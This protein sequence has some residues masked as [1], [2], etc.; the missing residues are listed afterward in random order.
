MHHLMAPELIGFSASHLLLRSRM[1]YGL[2][3][4]CISCINHAVS[5]THAGRHIVVSAGSRQVLM[6]WCLDGRPRP[7]PGTPAGSAP[8]SA[9]GWAPD[10]RPWPRHSW[11]ATHLPQQG[12][13]LNPKQGGVARRSGKPGKPGRHAR[14]SDQRYLA[15]AA[16]PIGPNP[17]PDPERGGSVGLSAPLHMP[18]VPTGAPGLPGEVTDAR[19]DAAAVPLSAGTSAAGGGTAGRC[20]A[21]RWNADKD[22]SAVGVVAAASDASVTLLCLDVAARRCS[23]FHGRMECLA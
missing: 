15:L 1:L 20:E 13:A 18:G 6:A 11:L 4:S 3:C 22:G 16:F 23:T 14:E 19:G 21:R 12:S 7:H 5:P 10:A 17:D 8:P 2:R 9:P